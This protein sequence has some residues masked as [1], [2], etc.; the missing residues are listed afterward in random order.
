[1]KSRIGGAVTV[2]PG[3]FAHSA[4]GSVASWA[5]SDVVGDSPSPNESCAACVGTIGTLADVRVEFF[6]LLLESGGQPAVDFGSDVVP[7]HL[8]ATASRR[9]QGLVCHASAVELLETSDAVA[10]TARCL[11]HLVARVAVL[12]RNTHNIGRCT[13]DCSRTGLGQSCFF[14]LE[15]ANGSVLE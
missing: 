7:G 3:G 10:V 9:V 1:M 5:E 6:L 12:A 4:G 13:S 11:P 14:A 8:A 15:L 2:V